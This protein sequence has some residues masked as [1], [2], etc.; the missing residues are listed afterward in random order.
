MPTCV[1]SV[2]AAPQSPHHHHSTTFHTLTP[3]P[4]QVIK[5]SFFNVK[6]AMDYYVS[7]GGSAKFIICDD[8]FQVLCG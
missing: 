8:G 7:K 5:L 4:P 6:E 2:S 3:L 1:C